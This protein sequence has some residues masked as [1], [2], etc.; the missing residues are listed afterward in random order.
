MERSDR[1][2]S[3]DSGTSVYLITWWIVYFSIITLD[4]GCTSCR[5]SILRFYRRLPILLRAMFYWKKIWHL[6]VNVQTK[7]GQALLNNSCNVSKV[8]AVGK[9]SRA[10]LSSLN[11]NTSNIW[12]L[13]WWLVVSDLQKYEYSTRRSWTTLTPFMIAAIGLTLARSKVKW[14]AGVVIALWTYTGLLNSM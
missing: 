1:K 7:Y 5:R 3:S 11:Q 6:C 8:C 13:F 14:M 10:V 9:T 4:T 12:Y 2:R